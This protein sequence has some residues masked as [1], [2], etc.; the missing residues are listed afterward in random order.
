M[1]ENNVI[2]SQ[3]LSK[4]TTSEIVLLGNIAQLNGI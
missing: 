2:L 1:E 4:E 3:L